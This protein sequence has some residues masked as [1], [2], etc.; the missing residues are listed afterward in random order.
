MASWSAAVLRAV[1]PPYPGAFFE[2]QGRQIIIERT[3]KMTS[4]Q[5]PADRFRVFA[6]DQALWLHA[7][8]GGCLRIL[9]LRLD[10]APCDAAA[11]E[12]CFGAAPVSADAA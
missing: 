2:A 10:G 1:A 4:T 7:A 11:F 8:D 5:A 9:A 3:L 12:H 6:R